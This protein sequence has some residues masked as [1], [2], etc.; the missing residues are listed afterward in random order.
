MPER[1][2]RPRIKGPDEE[3][4]DYEV[5]YGKPPAKT[6]FRKG[7]SGN[8]AGRPKGAKNKSV[9]AR[10][11]E[12]FNTIFVEE[13]YRQVKL[14]EGD[15]VFEVPAIQGAIRSRTTK[16][17]KGDYRSQK[18]LVGHLQDVEK[19]NMT[20]HHDWLA[21]AIEYKLGWQRELARRVRTGD[22]GPQPLP[23][24]DYIVINM[25]TDEVEIRGPMT[26]EEEVDWEVD[27]E[28]FQTRGEFIEQLKEMIQE[29]PKKQDLRD[30]LARHRRLNAELGARVG[31]YAARK[32]EEER[33]RK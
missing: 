6:Q 5:G 21:T 29:K 27:Q 16:A 32:Q 3:E 10:N 23:H 20:R 22:T 15:Q 9:P 26:K 25:D 17:I 19:E 13:V 18:L 14:R 28:I 7:Q 1:N 24:P 31:H 33:R 8:P 2:Q 12:R 11:E 30:A 4:P